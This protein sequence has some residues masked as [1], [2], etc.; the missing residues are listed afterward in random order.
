MPRRMRE[1]IDQ[2]ESKRSTSRDAPQ[3]PS[4]ATLDRNS[5]SGSFSM[6]DVSDPQVQQLLPTA[7]DP[8]RLRL[9]MAELQ[10]SARGREF[11]AFRDACGDAFRCGAG[12][13]RADARPERHGSGAV[14]EKV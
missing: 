13:R 7:G 12:A 5:F 3:E 1:N 14:L 4:S 9:A 8:E 11:A 10:A 6:T 2:L